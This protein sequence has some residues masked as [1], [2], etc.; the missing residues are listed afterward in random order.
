MTAKFFTFSAILNKGV[1]HVLSRI[2]E[3]DTELDNVEE[4]LCGTQLSEQNL[5]HLH[6]CRIPVVTEA[7]AHHSI[8]LRQY[9]L[10]DLPA[11]V[12]VWQHVRHLGDGFVHLSVAQKR[13]PLAINF[14]SQRL[15]C[16]NKQRARI[17]AERSTFLALS[18]TAVHSA[19]HLHFFP[20]TALCRN[21]STHKGMSTMA[22]RRDRNLFF[23]LQYF[24]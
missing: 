24:P 18:T 5:V 3:E 2:Q 21:I 15:L 9:R 8:L 17:C 16:E 10:I 23:P 14:S 20:S 19:S 6:T 4:I 12:Q 13:Y 7:N 22:Q 1:L 11:V